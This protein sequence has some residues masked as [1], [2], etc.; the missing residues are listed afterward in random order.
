M[1]GCTEVIYTTLHFKSRSAVRAP[2]FL[3]AE[4]RQGTAAPCPT[5]HP[6]HDHPALASTTPDRF[7]SGMV[8]GFPPE[9]LI[10][11][12]GILTELADFTR[13]AGPE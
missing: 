1:V 6:R 4:A 12:G 2:G 13:V 3:R 11:F 10:A 7:A 9:S 8:I 5:P